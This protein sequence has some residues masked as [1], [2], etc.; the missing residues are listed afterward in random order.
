MLSHRG[1]L[2]SNASG[3]GAPIQRQPARFLI[4]RLETLAGILALRD[5]NLAGAME[6][7]KRSGDA[8]NQYTGRRLERPPGMLLA[9]QLFKAG[10]LPAVVAYLDVC[11]QFEYPGSEEHTDEG[12]NPSSPAS[13]KTAILAGEAPQFPATRID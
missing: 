6:A 4:N 9:E 2:S 5:G 12:R 7:L 8:L 3:Y 13:L 11:A 1:T 10:Q